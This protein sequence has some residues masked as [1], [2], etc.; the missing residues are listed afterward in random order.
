LPH[1]QDFDWSVATAERALAYLK[2]LRVPPAPRHFELLFAYAAGHNQALNAALRNTV[3][4]HGGL[5]EPELERLLKTHLAHHRLNEKVGEVSADV[6]AE[7][8]KV[9]HNIEAA[10]RSTG[11]FS[12]SLEA[13]V[14]QLGHA[15]SAGELK[16]VVETLV[17]ATRHLAENSRELE[18]RITVSKQLIQDLHQDLE[19]VRADSLTDELTGIANRKR[20]GQVLKME[21][22]E[23]KE[24][25]DPLCLALADVDNFKR[26][27]DSFGHQAGDQVLR[28]IAQTLKHNIRSGAH[29][30]RY[31]GEEFA[32]LL[33]K[34]ELLDAVGLANTICTTVRARELVKKSRAQS[35]GHI[36]L[37]IGVAAYRSG[38]S[39]DA[40]VQRADECLYLA[41][42]RGRDRVEVDVTLAA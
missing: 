12:Q 1:E 38:E 15:L 39:E 16:T 3:L 28:L 25:G 27:N 33:P 11:D 22:F 18:K 41:K 37:S 19:A 26:L 23:A 36:T 29:A 42:Q 17:A 6:T 24:S 10:L 8:G 5:P 31:G 30:C 14:P 4:T 35:L 20:F 13:L 40:F 21:A 32:L 7:L 34:T 9:V 2:Q